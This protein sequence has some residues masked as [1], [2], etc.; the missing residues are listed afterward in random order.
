MTTHAEI[1]GSI[2]RHFAATISV[3]DETRMRAHLPGCVSCEARYRR[4]LLLASLD[5][6]VPSARRRLARGL[7]LRG[8]RPAR[9]WPARALVA[10][11]VLATLVFVVWPRVRRRPLP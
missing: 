10:A 7:G 4:H 11:T 5:R 3:E 6:R 2:D 1:V 8:A 9:A